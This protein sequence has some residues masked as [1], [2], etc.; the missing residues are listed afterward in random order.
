MTPPR[1]LL[2]GITGASG[3]AYAQM[4]LR[5]LL[6]LDLELHLIVSSSALLV[7]KEELGMSFA[8]GRLNVAEYV[9]VDVPEGRVIQYS[10]TDLAAAPA[11]GSFRHL[12]MVI[13]PCS[14][15]TLATV[16]HGTGESLVTRAADAC[17][18]E[19]R[20]LVL[21][22]R[23]TPLNLIHLKNMVSVTE[24]GAVVLPAMPGFYKQPKTIDDLLQHV[25][26]KIMDSLGL[27]HSINLRWKDTSP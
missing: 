24:A 25:V 7:M 5:E 22:P 21:V 19:R 3:T 1:R 12:G 16:A 6:K 11:S 17:L 13:C 10:A 18:K 23:E 26:L 20:R 9:G 14:M 8:G 2:V 27:E 4:L 15:R